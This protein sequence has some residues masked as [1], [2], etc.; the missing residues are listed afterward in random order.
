MKIDNFQLLNIPDPFQID[1]STNYAKY[2]YLQ[3]LVDTAEALIE[4]RVNQDPGI[5]VRIFNALN[6]HIEFLKE[7]TDY[8]QFIDQSFIGKYMQVLNKLAF[9]LE[10]EIIA[11]DESI[12]ALIQERERFQYAL[13]GARNAMFGLNQLIPQTTEE[14]VFE[15]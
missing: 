1:G 4:N 8:I 12:H 11:Q 13:T 15:G 9:F 14:Q 7:S 2:I 6:E 10:G 3:G 5:A